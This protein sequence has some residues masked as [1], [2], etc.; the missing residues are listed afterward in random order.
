LV[1]LQQLRHFLF[2]CT[3][4][5]IPAIAFV[6]VIRGTSFADDFSV[7]LIERLTTKLGAPTRRHA[8]ANNIAHRWDLKADQIDGYVAMIEHVRPLPVDPFGLQ[9][10]VV[11]A[12]LSFR[13]L[14]PNTDMVLPGQDSELYGYFSPSPG[15]LLGSSQLF[16][17]ISGRS[18]VSLFLNFPFEEQ[19]DEFLDTAAHVQASLSFP[20]SQKHWKQWRLTKKGTSYL[21]RRISVQIEATQTPS[22]VR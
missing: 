14:N 22:N 3:D 1:A 21:G 15:Q 18:T 10:F 9:P 13:L 5:S 8:G 20:L 17:R 2:T 11:A 4:T 19:T 12:H 16:A 6:E 7:P